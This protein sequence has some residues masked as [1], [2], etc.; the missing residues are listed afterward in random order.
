MQLHH[1][2]ISFSTKN[3]LLRSDGSVGLE[4]NCLSF[5]GQALHCKAKGNST[6]I[7]QLL[8]SMTDII[9]MKESIRY[10]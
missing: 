10:F 2:C 7:Y 9:E 4:A 5:R 6:Y 8:Q 1:L 3:M